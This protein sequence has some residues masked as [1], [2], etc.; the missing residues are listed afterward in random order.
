MKRCKIPLIITIALPIAIA[1]FWL[2][3]N[4]RAASETPEY[5]VIRTEDKF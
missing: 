3:S 1:A 4:S 2:V 5:K